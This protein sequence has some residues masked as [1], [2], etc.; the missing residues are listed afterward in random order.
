MPP[1]DAS[2]RKKPYFCPFGHRDDNGAATYA[3]TK[4]MNTLRL[5]KFA[6]AASAALLAATLCAQDYNYRMETFEQE[7]WG[8]AAT[9]V[10]ATTGTWTTNKNVQSTEQACQG[11]YSLKLSNLAEGDISCPD[12]E[13]NAQFR[14]ISLLMKADAM[15]VT[16]Y[17]LTLYC[18]GAEILKYELQ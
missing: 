15:V 2:S 3:K 9:S 17:T 8:T 13:M 12:A 16:E 18:K 6:M 7:A 11:A 5:M 4:I 14:Y 1:H 10:T